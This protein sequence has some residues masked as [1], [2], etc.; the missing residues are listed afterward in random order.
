MPN[1]LVCWIQ[2][3]TDSDGNSIIQPTFWETRKLVLSPTH[4]RTNIAITLK[5]VWKSSRNTAKCKLSI[6]KYVQ[7]KKKAGWEKTPWDSKIRIS[8]YKNKS[9][10]WLWM[11]PMYRKDCHSKHME[12]VWSQGMPCPEVL[13]RTEHWKHLLEGSPLLR[14]SLQ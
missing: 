3:Q 5:T 6:C 2:E 14:D 11:K 13:A 4:P 10:C 1:Y 8:S 9:T 7:A 12:G